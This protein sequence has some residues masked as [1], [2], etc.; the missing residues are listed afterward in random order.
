M[1]RRVIWAMPLLLVLTSCNRKAE[2]QTVAVVNNEEIT[3]TELN[4]ELRAA[5]VPSD[6]SGKQV[7]SQILQSLIDR[8]LLA[9]QAKSSD[10]DKSP[11]YLNQQRKL[12]ENLLINLL[13]SR[14]ANSMQVPSESD[15][16]A[17]EASHPNMFANRQKWTLQ[18]LQYQTPT[19]PALLARISAAKSLDQ[20]ASVLGSSG[21]QLARKTI[22]I[23][24]G[25]FP[26]EIYSKVISLP[27]GE[28]FIIPGGNQSVASVISAREPIALSGDQA[29]AV[30]VQAIRR[31]Q[32]EKLLQDR[33]KSARSAAKI[34]YKPGFAPTKN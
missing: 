10:I 3:A 4:A 13:V 33:I 20:L 32:V 30:A 11:E 6:A 9:Q 26:A 25:V 2:G 17:F 34:E 1:Y 14:Q 28:P 22:P 29:K 31:Q 24:T 23:D 27:A 5:N 16:A 15:I 7:R 8:R 18:Q 21:I 12:T 19:D